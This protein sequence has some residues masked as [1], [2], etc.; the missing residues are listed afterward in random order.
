[1]GQDLLARFG[2]RGDR[3]G[4]RAGAAPLRLLALSVV[5][6][7]ALGMAIATAW[8]PSGRTA[9]A[10]AALVAAA[11]ALAVL[12]PREATAPVA[13][14]GIPQPDGPSPLLAQ[15]HHELRTPL[16]AVI[17]FSEVMRSEL[18]GPLGNARYQEYVAHISESSG[19]LL[20]ASED[21]LAVATTMSALLADRRALRRDRLPAAALVQEAWAALEAPARGVRLRLEDCAGI[22]IDCDPQATRQ[23]LRHLLG[24]AAA[25]TPAGGTLAAK[26]VRGDG[27]SGIEI[28]LPPIASGDGAVVAHSPAAPEAAADC[29][30]LILARSLIEMQGATLGLGPQHRAEWWARIVFPA[31]RPARKAPR[32]HGPSAAVRWPILPAYRAGFCADGAARAISRSQPAPPA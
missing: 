6:G 27:A 24:E 5:A 17:G 1:M 16:N 22:V 9:L 30:R 32:P 23:A 29:L 12:Y 4:R 26:G 21:A 25:R 3:Q 13:E 14:A 19:R 20:K 18:H 11:A 31:A 8:Q 28:S 15:M 10:L 7:L 2:W